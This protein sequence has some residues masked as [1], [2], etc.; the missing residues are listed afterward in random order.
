MTIEISNIE[1]SNFKDLMERF[2]QPLWDRRKVEL[3]QHRVDFYFDVKP[4]ING[5]HLRD[6]ESLLLS[7][8]FATLDH[9]CWYQ[10]KK[11]KENCNTWMLHSVMKITDYTEQREYLTLPLSLLVKSAHRFKIDN[12]SRLFFS[13]TLPL[14]FFIESEWELIYQPLYVTLFLEGQIE[15][16]L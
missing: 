14:K 7:S 1:M 3:G 10:N 2:S 6:N 15:R 11:I 13:K 4:G 9:Y 12:F 5:R 16:A 8:I